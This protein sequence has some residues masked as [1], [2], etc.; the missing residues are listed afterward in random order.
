MLSL[1]CLAALALGTYMALAPTEG[2][3]NYFAALA[4]PTIDPSAG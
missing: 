3:P 2:R 4:S 1:L